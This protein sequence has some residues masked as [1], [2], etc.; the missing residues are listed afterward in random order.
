MGK[1][2]L[3][4]QDLGQEA[5][6]K[7]GIVVKEQ[8]VDE[9]QVVEMGPVDYKEIAKKGQQTKARKAA[10]AMRERV[11]HVVQAA[12]TEEVEEC[13]IFEKWDRLTR[14]VTAYQEARA[15]RAK[16]NQLRQ[17]IREELQESHDNG[18]LHELAQREIGF[19]KQAGPR[20]LKGVW[21]PGV[22][23]KDLTQEER[24][25]LRS[26]RFQL[27]RDIEEAMYI[28]LLPQ[29][30]GDIETIEKANA[31]LEQHESQK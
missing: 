31:V 10:D 14:D 17:F 16:A 25:E 15:V 30:V 13:G 6:K 9:G 23:P 4:L 7:L 11:R 21:L 5:E 20:N 3:T 27:A 2:K 8:E 24:N 26:W 19:D 22:H 18:T 1:Q 12:I 29:E 28:R